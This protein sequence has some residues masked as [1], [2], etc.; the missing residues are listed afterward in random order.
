[1]SHIHVNDNTLMP[2][3]GEPGY[4]K[5]YKIRPVIDSLKSTFK[6]YYAQHKTR[7]WTNACCI[8]L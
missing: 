6:K 3:K 5:L 1:L 2:K 4:D 7:Q 8:F